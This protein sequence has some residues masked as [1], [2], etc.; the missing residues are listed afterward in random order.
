MGNT[1]RARMLEAAAM[2]SKAETNW[3]AWRL[4]LG[5]KHLRPAVCAKMTGLKI[6][7]DVILQIPIATW[8]KYMSKCLV[9]A[10]QS[11][12]GAQSKSP[13]ERANGKGMVSKTVDVDGAMQWKWWCTR[14][15][16]LRRNVVWCASAMCWGFISSQFA[17]SGLWPVQV[18]TAKSGLWKKEARVNARI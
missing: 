1:N 5:W 10:E 17:T 13:R 15:S 6:T 18:A 7:I 4:K 9:W 14:R 2:T 16:S 8:K 12:M 3:F 11:M